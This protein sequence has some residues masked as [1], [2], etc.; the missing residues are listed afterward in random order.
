[1]GVA[2]LLLL[3]LFLVISFITIAFIIRSIKKKSV[4]GIII[5][6]IMAFFL[7]YILSLNTIDELSIN[8]NDVNKDLAIFDI[9]LNNDFKII[10]NNVSGIVERNQETKIEIHKEDAGK[11]TNE[12]KVSKNFRDLSN[13]QEILKDTSVRSGL[14]PNEILNYKYPD[15]YSK[16]VYTDIDNIPTHVYLYIKVLNGKN[17]LHYKKIED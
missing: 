13:T 3:M 4:V 6:S 12:I 2:L 10:D 17:I 14:N 9:H 15:S 8:N 7:C 1:M 16:E 5:S 11:V